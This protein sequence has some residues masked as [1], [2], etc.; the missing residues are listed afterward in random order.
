MNI[1]N[2]KLNICTGILL[3]LFLTLSSGESYAQ[4]Y[5]IVY[6][7]DASG[8]RISRTTVID[9]GTSAMEVAQDSTDLA[10]QTLNEKM[11]S[12]IRFESFDKECK[13]IL[14]PNPTKGNLTFK[15]TPFNDE[16]QGGS[17]MVLDL[18]GRMVYSTNKL[19]QVN[20]I[21]L[22]N[23]PVGTYILKLYYASN[24]KY[25]KLLKK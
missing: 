20:S 4:D 8:N 16:Q 18:S 2:L 23:Q 22:T 21:D 1:H 10:F 12:T 6:K 11:D 3:L 7:Y 14:Y 25:W 17:L 15:I 9:M 5:S 13:Y 19:Q 24:E